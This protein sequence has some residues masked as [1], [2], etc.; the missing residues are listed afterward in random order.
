[1]IHSRP[2]NPSFQL[3]C[4]PSVHGPVANGVLEPIDGK[5]NELEVHWTVH[6]KSEVIIS[7]I[8]MSSR[9]EEDGGPSKETKLRQT[10]ILAAF[11]SEGPTSTR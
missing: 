4:S 3:F 6:L 7:L 1:M 10:S 8:R 2:Q 5:L 11:S 9:K